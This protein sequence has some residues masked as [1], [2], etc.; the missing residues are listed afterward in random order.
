VLSLAVSFVITLGAIVLPAPLFGGPYGEVVPR[1]VALILVGALPMTTLAVLSRRDGDDRS[2]PLVAPT[3]RGA[4]VAVAVIASM[5]VPFAI[6]GVPA[7]ATAAS[8]EVTVTAV[9]AHTV[10]GE[11]VT[12]TAQVTGKITTLCRSMEDR[13]DRGKG[14]QV[15]V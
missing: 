12:L 2:A 13:Q 9:S 1:L 5:I 6:V 4:R 15:A 10:A 8:T 7:S 3:T 14:R 11:E